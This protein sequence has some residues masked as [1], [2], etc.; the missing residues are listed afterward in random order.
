MYDA[1]ALGGSRWKVGRPGSTFKGHREPQGE[2][3]EVA[4][5]ADVAAD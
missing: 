1:K 5:P 2:N 3:S 4:E